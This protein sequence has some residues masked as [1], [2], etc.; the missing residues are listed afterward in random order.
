MLVCLIVISSQEE[1]SLF[2]ENSLPSLRACKIPIKVG[3]RNSILAP[4]LDQSEAIYL[5]DFHSLAEINRAQ[6]YPHVSDYKMVL[7]NDP[8]ERYT[9]LL[10][11][12]ALA[13]TVKSDE[14]SVGCLPVK[15]YFKGV[16]LIGTPFGGLKFRPRIFVPSHLLDMKS[17]HGRVFHPYSNIQCQDHVAHYWADDVVELRSRHNRYLKFEADAM[18]ARYGTPNITQT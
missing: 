9:T 17:V 14:T 1:Y 15:Y 10:I 12:S 2:C 18:K 6:V 16:A 13:W 8:D 5:E 7:I 3:L 11:E 4:G